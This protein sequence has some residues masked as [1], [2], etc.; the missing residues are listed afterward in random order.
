MKLRGIELASKLVGWLRSREAEPMEE[1]E[2]MDGGEVEE[3]EDALDMFRLVREANL[4]AVGLG[5]LGSGGGEGEDGGKGGAAARCI[6]WCAMSLLE[7]SAARTLWVSAASSRATRVGRCAAFRTSLRRTSASSLA[8]DCVRCLRRRLL[9]ERRAGLRSRSRLHSH[10]QSHSHSHAHS[11]SRVLPSGSTRTTSCSGAAWTAA[12]S[13]PMPTFEVEV[14]LEDEGGE[15]LL[16]RMPSSRKPAGRP[17]DFCFSVL[18]SSSVLRADRV[19]PSFCESG[20]GIGLSG[21]RLCGDPGWP[22]QTLLI[23]SSSPTDID[24][25]HARF[26]LLPPLLLLVASLALKSKSSSEFRS[27]PPKS[28][29]LS[30]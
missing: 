9:S 11:R 2:K 15:S 6:C 18:T 13:L 19:F 12:M 5:R 1:L 26:L 22:I 21:A 28:S 14:G 3:T 25:F 23:A 10:S 7:S 27:G 16:R 8:S 24:V 20:S 4:S 17:A 29:T 30:C